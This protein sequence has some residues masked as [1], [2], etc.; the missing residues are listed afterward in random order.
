MGTRGY[1]K[2][3]VV[4][5]AR[6]LGQNSWRV[7]QALAKHILDRHGD[8]YQA[9]E[10]Y[11]NQQHGELK[12]W[13]TVDALTLANLIATALINAS[14][15]HG[16]IR[17]SQQNPN[18][19]LVF[20]W[21]QD[22]IGC[23]GETATQCNQIAIVIEL[24]NSLENCRIVTAFPEDRKYGDSWPPATD[25]ATGDNYSI[26]L[27][28]ETYSLLEIPPESS[29]AVLAGKKAILENLRLDNLVTGL[30]RAAGLV[31]VAQN[32]VA[33]FGSLMAAMTGLSDGIIKAASDASLTL[34]GFADESKTILSHLKRSMTFLL[35][36]QEDLAVKFLT[37]CGS[38]AQEMSTQSSKLADRFDK[39]G[40]QAIEVLKNTQ[41]E[42]GRQH[43]KI[44][45]ERR[46]IA[47]LQADTAEAKTLSEQLAT[48]RVELK[49]MYEDAKAK[50]DKA[51]E[52][53]F[54]LQI[55]GAI[56]G[57]IGS[58]LNS[59]A[60]GMKP[61]NSAPPQAESPAAKPTPPATGKATTPPEKS[62]DANGS[63]AKKSGSEKETEAAAKGSADASN[64]VSGST[65]K[66]ASSQQDAAQSYRSEK[67]KYLDKLL[68]AEEKQRKALADIAKY[69][70]LLKS[71]AQ[72]KQIAETT[73]AALHQAV[74][75]LKSIASTL[76]DNSFFWQLMAQACQKL[77][78]PK[79]LEVIKEMKD[80]SLEERLEIYLEDDFKIELITYYAQWQALNLVC[81]EYSAAVFEAR[82]QML[83]D[84]QKNP[85]IEEA[86][87]QAPVLAAQLLA[88]TQ[89]DLKKLD[90]R[91][92]AIDVE[93]KVLSGAGAATV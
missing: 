26:V 39:L 43:E 25:S 60:G 47:Q 57:A 21:V 3:Y 16:D 83:A 61:G 78:A 11:L 20:Y 66:M 9:A 87:K 31:Y 91:R 17:R 88:D 7:I 28:G 41:V 58:G 12:S 46:K 71:T 86:Q 37:K 82:A 4:D 24:A 84:F 33:G 49:T 45:E 90:E 40:D 69:A 38:S 52:R 6:F 92:A 5:A 70:E 44:E 64:A 10:W 2:E 36:G 23:I 8:E 54:A 51:A 81:N 34:S 79:F 15:S 65:N 19:A 93:K 1:S 22:V 62:G 14:N 35:K 80:L 53:A 74:G 63:D 73:A 30:N 18:R 29:K 13:F 48:Q 59:F 50:E 56:F 68:E 67:M 77:A 42:Q 85:T 27:S 32:G 72:E 75:A 55:V 76:R 89:A